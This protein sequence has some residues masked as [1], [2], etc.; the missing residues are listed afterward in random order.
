MISAADNC[1]IHMWNKGIPKT[2]QSWSY[3]MQRYILKLSKNGN[4]KEYLLS[5]TKHLNLLHK[6]MVFFLDVNNIE[7]S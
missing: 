6:R 1:K 7:T 3:L 2:R 5:L 4:Y